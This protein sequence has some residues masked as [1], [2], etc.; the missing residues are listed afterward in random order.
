[1]GSFSS[2]RRL[3]IGIRKHSTVQW[4][5]RNSVTGNKYVYSKYRGRYIVKK[6]C[7]RESLSQSESRFLQY[8]FPGT[9]KIGGHETSYK[10]ETPQCVSQNT[11]FQN[12]LNENSSKSGKKGRFRI[13]SRSGRRLPTH[14][15][16]SQS[17][18]IST[19]LYKQTSLSVSS[20]G[21][22]TKSSS[23]NVHK[24]CS[25]NSRLSSETESKTSGLPRRLVSSQCITPGIDARSRENI[26]SP[27]ELGICNKSKKV[28]TSSNSIDYLH[29]RGVQ[30]EKGNCRTHIRTQTENNGSSSDYF[31]K[32]ILNSQGI[33]TT[34]GLAS[35][36]CRDNSECQ[37]IH[38]TDSVVPSSLLETQFQRFDVQNP[39]TKAS[40]STSTMVVSYSKHFTGKMFSTT[41]NN[42][43]FANR[44]K[45]VC[46]GSNTGKSNNAG[47]VVSRG[48]ED[49][50]KWSR[51]GGGI[52]SSS[53][54]SSECEESERTNSIRQYH[55][56][57]ISESSGRN[58]LSLSMYV[59]L[60]NLAVSNSEQNASQSSSHS[61][62]SKYSTRSIVTNSDQTNR[63]V[64]K[65]SSSVSDFSEMGIPDDRSVRITHEQTDS[66]ILHMDTTSRS[67]SIG[68]TNNFMGEN[69]RICISSHMPDTKG[70][71][72]HETI[73]VHDNSNSTHV[74]KETLVHR[75][76]GNVCSTTNTNS[77]DGKSTPSA[78]VTNIPPTSRSVPIDC[79]VAIDQYYT[80]EGFS[81][82]ARTLLKSSWR[83]GTKQD[84]NSKYKRFSRW[85]NQR[86]INVFSATVSQCADFL[87]DLFHEG[88]QY[89][90]ISGYRSMLSTILPPIKDTPIGQHPHIIRILKG[91]F[92]ERPP[93]TRLLPEWDLHL[94]LEM[95][96]KSPFEPLSKANLKCLTYKTIF[97]VAITTFR[98]V[99]DLQALRIGDGTMT[100]QDR[101]ITFL[102]QGLSKQDR[103]NHIS[104][105]IFVPCFS[106]NKLLDPKRTLQFYLK[107]T[108][109]FRKQLKEPMLFIGINS[110]HKQVTKQ[111]LSHWIVKTIQMAYEDKSKKVKA[112]STRSL[113]P[114]WALY[115]GASL[116]SI[117]E[118]ADWSRKDTFMKFYY[119][120][121]E[122]SVLS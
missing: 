111:T 24:M 12:G 2:S 88:L 87:A 25:S 14:T 56:G 70:D 91:V 7:N 66:N 28:T 42:S 99:G 58:A 122:T 39:I 102:R 69:V 50:Y 85:C 18:E 106:E 40:N 48:K 23:K 61:R 38:E 80:A 19:I 72:T 22:R 11:T 83:A 45:H 37:I 101:G 67:P 35:V 9:Q 121:V 92:N 15:D 93:Q 1:M 6:R 71:T 53:A 103:P 94:V 5:K 114:S 52:Q 16:I 65:L 100:V 86:E 59:D 31:N 29:R 63:V 73:S 110:P 105:K 36:M 13:F 41:T 47:S 55:S 21:V 120:N 76:S 82:K 96:Q 118:A 95:L 98:R 17:Q 49:A 112:H 90:T 78:Q 108:N 64:S 77:S 68:C 62:V 119:R 46:M 26:K 32:S 104:P 43:D 89:R 27:Y 81:N 3:Q 20:D 79:M 97:L 109:L 115:K 75:S 74:A 116:A 34:S 60:E 33:F 51:N 84:Y 44:C 107:K 30:S 54:F 57:T 8:I 113:G 117:L 4:Y 10:P